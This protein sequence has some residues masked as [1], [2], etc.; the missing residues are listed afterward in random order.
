MSPFPAQPL[1]AAVAPAECRGSCFGTAAPIRA[2]QLTSGLLNPIHT[3]LHWF[4][5]VKEGDR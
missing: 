1:A 4:K 2:G 5:K 3:N